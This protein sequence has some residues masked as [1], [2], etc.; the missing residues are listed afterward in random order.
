MEGEEP[1]KMATP[2]IILEYV[3]ILS[4]RWASD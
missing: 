1:G 2:Q 3:L 4:T